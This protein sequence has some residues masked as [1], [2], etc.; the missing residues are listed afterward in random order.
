M[1]I[2]DRLEC[3]A[4]GDNKRNKCGSSVDCVTMTLASEGRS[5]EESYYI[6]RTL[7]ELGYVW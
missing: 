3:V 6:M 1:S 5:N 7:T 4:V 2:Y